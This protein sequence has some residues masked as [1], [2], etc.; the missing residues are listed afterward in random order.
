VIR[1]RYGKLSVEAGKIW[2]KNGETGRLPGVPE[3]ILAD[4]GE[5]HK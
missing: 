3:F 1:N 2:L 5:R 4:F